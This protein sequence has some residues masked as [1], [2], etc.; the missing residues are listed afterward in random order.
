VQFLFEQIEL[1]GEGV[2]KTEIHPLHQAAKQTFLELF[3]YHEYH[4]VSTD[5]LKQTPHMD[6]SKDC[7]P[8]PGFLHEQ[9]IDIPA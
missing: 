4:P 3:Q 9:I 5:G 1:Y 6:A 7:S 2:K 8:L